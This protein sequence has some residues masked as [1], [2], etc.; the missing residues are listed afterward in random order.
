MLH[1]VPAIAP[2]AIAYVRVSKERD[3]MISPELQLTAIKDHC[4]RHGYELTDVIEDLDMS[5]RFWKRRHMEQA[6]AMIEQRQAEVIVVWKQSRVSR[7]RLDWN[8]AVDRIE[9]AG[10]RLESATEPIDTSTSSG[11]LARGMLAE[12]A[13]FEAERAGEQWKETHRRRLAKGIPATGKA[14]FGYTNTPDGFV[15]NED[16]AEIAREGI[17]R[18]LS[19]HGNV[20]IAAFFK[21]AG[22]GPATG[23]GVVTWLDAG[24][25]AGLLNYHDPNCPTPHPTYIPKSCPNRITRPG[26]HEPLIDK[27]TWEQVRAARKQRSRPGSGR[28]AKSPYTGVACCT[29]CGSGMG[30]R[31]HSNGHVQMVCGN[32]DCDAPC[33]V[34]ESRVDALVLD[35]LRGVSPL[36][37]GGSSASHAATVAL[38]ERLE[39]Q[40]ADADKALAQLTVDFARRT[41]PEGAYLVARDQLTADRDANA[42]EAAELR[43]RTVDKSLEKKALLEAWDELDVL[44]KN[45]VL[46]TLCRVEVTRN[47]VLRG[48]AHIRLVPLWDEYT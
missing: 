43:A 6:V 41:I 46:K 16:E 33:S 21:A 31:R 32:S 44:G 25:Y 37:Q 47:E 48:P 24:F 29:S 1:A 9:S 42:R 30:R 19:G 11:R 5:G 14:R 2:R 7:N 26:A 15:I 12:I 27:G 23:R 18:Y 28:K 20:R 22:A 3:D 34:S 10:G 39:R 45:R 40:A 38:A 36:V 13:A 8:I 35:W 4:H 17:R